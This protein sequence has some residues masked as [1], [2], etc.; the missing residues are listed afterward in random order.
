MLELCDSIKHNGNR[1]FIKTLHRS[2]SRRGS[3]SPKSRLRICRENSLTGECP[4][5]RRSLEGLIQVKSEISQLF[6]NEAI[7]TATR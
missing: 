7:R 3:N 1:R 5:V 6:K 4:N 2:S